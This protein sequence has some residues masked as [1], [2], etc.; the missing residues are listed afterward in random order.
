MTRVTSYREIF[1]DLP[2]SSIQ[3]SEPSNDFP[4]PV[5]VI[6]AGD[7]GMLNRINRHV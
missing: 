4:V 3:F 7:L 5:C 1:R 2:G 6:T